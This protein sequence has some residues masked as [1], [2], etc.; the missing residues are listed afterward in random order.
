[1]N[2]RG[3][4]AGL[5]FAAMAAFVVLITS[6]S[7]WAQVTISSGTTTTQNFD[8]IGT[9][10]TAP[11]PSG[12]KADKQTVERAVGTF[13]GA[14]LT[15]TERAGGD[16]TITINGF[17]NFGAGA[18]ASAPDRAVG[19]LASGTATKS[20]N[21]YV[22]L[23]NTGMTTITQ[24]NLNYNVEKHRNG[25]NAAGFTI[26]LYT[27]TDDVTYSPATGFT[28]SFPA[29]A[30][31]SGF[32]PAPGASVPVS[33]TLA[34]NIPVNG[35][36]YL[37]FNYSVT[38]G[39]TTTNAQALA[40]DDI[41]IAAAGGA[42]ATPPSFSIND[43][44]QAEGNSGTTNFTF[45]VTKTGT[46]S[47]GSTVTFATSDGTASA[48]TDY[49]ANSGTSTFAAGDTSRTISV[50]V[51]GDTDVEADETFF[52]NLTA[53]TN[54]TI[55]DNQGVG[56]ITNDDSSSPTVTL[57]APGCQGLATPPLAANT[58]NR[59]LMCF[60]LSANNGASFTG[61]TVQFNSDPSVK[62]KNAKLFGSTDTDYS[63]KGDNVF[64]A[65]GTIDTTKFTFTGFAAFSENAPGK[66]AAPELTATPT[67]FFVVADVLPTVDS[68]TPESTPTVSPSDIT[69]NPPT[70]VTGATATSPAPV[71]FAAAG[72]TAAI[73]NVGGHVLSARGRGIF[74]AIVKMTDG[75]GNVR[76]AYT[77]NFGYYRFSEVE[78]GQTLVFTVK[79]KGYQF[80]QPTQVVSL[81]E[82]TNAVNFTA[83]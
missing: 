63:T 62:Y 11:L 80:S 76:R 36:Y 69:T 2:I 3:I 24:L 26:Q 5:S 67:I 73:V 23:Q 8:G 81:T 41:S 46:T 39:S 65:N 61:L 71:T 29:D 59:A 21:L 12:F 38:T 25:T 34:V 45:T 66:I 58:A 20:G 51:N 49:A 6:V 28:T 9:T 53:G 4:T 17:Y 43:V 55:T 30:N 64:L 31:N 68:S 56:T 13:S 72:P 42:G 40:I 44:T 10:A 77:N 70:N 19:F 54:A 22:Q 7:A 48:G 37:A 57:G 14:P 16:G 82:E 1:M 15:A 78:V 35:F 32:T 75:A 60:S 47:T 83:Y 74:R 27:S 33:G 18:A 52:V 50:T 79:S